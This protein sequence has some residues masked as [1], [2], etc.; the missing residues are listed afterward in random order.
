VVWARARHSAAVLRNSPAR[1]VIG[2]QPPARAIS[3]NNISRAPRIRSSKSGRRQ[4]HDR[5]PQAKPAGTRW[6][7]NQGSILRGPEGSEGTTREPLNPRIDLVGGGRSP[8]T[9]ANRADPDRGR[10]A[11]GF[12][13]R[14]QLDPAGMARRSG[15][16]GDAGKPRQDL[17]ADLADKGDVER[18]RQPMRGMPVQDHASSESLLQRLPEAVA[19]HA[20]A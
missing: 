12:E 8:E 1:S 19:Q 13:N 6:P 10:H 18:V 11:H 16:R 3:Q 17:G 15:R 9:E 5:P 7:T 2:K 4:M 14:R 20:H